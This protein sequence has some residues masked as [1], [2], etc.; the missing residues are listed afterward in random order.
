MTARQK[1]I[2]WYA[3]F[4]IDGERVRRFGFDSREAAEKWE[5]DQRFVRHAP[6]RRRNKPVSAVPVASPQPSPTP[7]GAAG[8]TTIVDLTRHVNRIRWGS[9]KS[10]AEH[11]N[12]LRFVKWVGPLTPVA[13]A[14]EQTKV[15]DYIEHLTDE[16]NLSGST[17]NRRLSPISCLAKAA[18]PL[19][20]I[21]AKPDIPRQREGQGRIR[22][23]TDE[24]EA[25]IL[26]TL[27]LWGEHE[28]RDLFIFLVDTGARLSE[29]IKLRW[30][31]MPKGDR[32]AT[33]W[34]T[35]SG[36]SRTVPLTIRAREAIARRRAVGFSLAG[37]F[38]GI[39]V[40][41]LHTLWDR[42]R[43]HLD[44]L[45]ETAVIHTFR[46]TCASRLVQK[47]VDIMRVKMW[48]GHKAIQTTLRYAHLA[49]K[50]LDDVLRALEGQ[51]ASDA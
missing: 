8:I 5:D 46:H 36:D 48:M 2:L 13:E 29:A 49:P 38:A 34:D 33:F 10:E 15:Y 19:R 32:S 37:P 50:H 17:I 31:D 18:V 28:E 20:L 16:L 1:G 14:L 21:E 6:T 7:V 43:G 22:W 35:K 39:N 9:Q 30:E 47:G 27:A 23:Y 3:D 11:N 26:K 45:D 42:L 40:N 4:M 41:T 51:P 12:C 25:T 24:E 44:F